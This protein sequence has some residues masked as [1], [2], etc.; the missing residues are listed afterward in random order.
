MQMPR[1]TYFTIMTNKKCHN[2][3][4]PKSIMPARAP[5]VLGV[6]FC[7]K[8]P[9]LPNNIKGTINRFETAVRR[10]AW[11]QENPPETE[12]GETTYLHP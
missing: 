1:K 12:P 8:T 10:I 3:C 11:I 6:K 9:R 7:I 2:Y 5:P 4:D